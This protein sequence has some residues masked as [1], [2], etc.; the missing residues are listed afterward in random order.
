MAVT[1]IWPVKN[2]VSAV[3]KYACNPNKTTKEIKVI[4][5]SLENVIAYAADEIKTEK[6]EYVTGIN[7]RKDNAVKV[8]N[9]TRKRW[10]RSKDTRVCYHAYQSFLP[11][12]VTTRKAHQIGIELAKTLYGDRFE[13]LV[14]THVTSRCIH[15]H[16]VLNAVSFVD[17]KKFCNYKS[18][19]KKLRDVSDEICERHK[20][21]VLTESPIHTPGNKNEVWIHKSGKTSKRDMIIKDIE[22]C[23][24]YS[25]D[26]YDFNDHLKGLGY[27]FDYYRMTI[28]ASSWERPKRL[29]TLGFTRED[30]EDRFY[31]NAN[32]PQ[33]YETTWETHPPYKPTKKP[34][35]DLLEELDFTVWHAKSPEK[36]FIAAVFYIIL[37]LFDLAFNMADYFIQ[38]HEL[39]YEM[40]DFKHYLSDY[41]F[42]Q[43]NKIETLEDL[44]NDIESTKAEIARLEKQRSDID[45]KRRRAT[46]PGDIQFYKDKRKELTQKITPLRK[47][48]KQAEKIW[49][50]SPHL[51]E[52]VK[53]E[54]SL[55]EKAIGRYRNYNRGER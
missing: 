2:N 49:D 11:D 28:K 20:L 38:S 22:Y 5:H 18:D 6:C 24:K 23:L 53:Q 9:E 44:H 45:N 16:I 8:F 34:I 14:A 41:H 19:Y 1:S 29:K 13:V 39:R 51:L 7:C 37:S 52:L 43:N 30:I 3:I 10:G 40:K 4:M 42:M 47:R 33:F 12:E 15:N 46:T 55:E 31:E 25:G 48:L 50:K 54:Q 36:V 17:G 27:S 21:S 32:T 26:Y 35:T